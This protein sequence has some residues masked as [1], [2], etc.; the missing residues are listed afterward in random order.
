MWEVSGGFNRERKITRTWILPNESS[1][2]EKQKN[3]WEFEVFLKCRNRGNP[4]GVL[5]RQKFSPVVQMRKVSARADVVE[6]SPTVQ[7]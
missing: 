3:N 7:K 1:K 6:S 5:R 4:M 2:K